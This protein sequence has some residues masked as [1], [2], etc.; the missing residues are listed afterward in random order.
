MISTKGF[1]FRP[2]CIV[3]AKPLRKNG[4]YTLWHS[5]CN[6]MGM[7]TFNSVIDAATKALPME[8]EE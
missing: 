6:S 2:S 7:K 5:K 4:K 8:V 1:P 3:C